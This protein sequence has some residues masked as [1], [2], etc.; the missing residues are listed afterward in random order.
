[1]KLRYVIELPIKHYSQKYNFKALLNFE[2]NL[3]D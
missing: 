2:F 1:M 3:I